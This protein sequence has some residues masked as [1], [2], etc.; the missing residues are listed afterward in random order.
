ML[1]DVTLS[2]VLL[3]L[4]NWSVQRNPVR[5][6]LELVVNGITPV[7]TVVVVETIDI[8][9]EGVSEEDPEFSIADSFNVEPAILDN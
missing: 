2:V 7:V 6:M 5:V 3:S 1:F 9:A 4:D 8:V